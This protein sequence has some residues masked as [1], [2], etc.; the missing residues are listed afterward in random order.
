MIKQ[1]SFTR[2]M[3]DAV[4]H[5]GSTIEIKRRHDFGGVQGESID[6]LIWLANEPGFD[7][8]I[9]AVE[10][11]FPWIVYIFAN[12]DLAFAFKMRWG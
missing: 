5:T 7:N 2:V 12:P 9:Y 11:Q 8:D 1:V 3:V 10:Q 4:N 6:L